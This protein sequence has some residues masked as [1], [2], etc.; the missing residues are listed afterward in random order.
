MP[1]EIPDIN[2][3]TSISGRKGVQPRCPF[4]TVNNCPRFYQSLSLL[5]EAGSTRIDSK[6]DKRLLKRWKKSDL[7]PKTNEYATSIT[8][9]ECAPHTFSNFCPEVAYDRFGY[10]A[11]FL[12]RYADEID[13]N[14]EHAKLGKEGVSAKDWRW[15]WAS[16]SKMHYAECPLYSV[17]ANR[18]PAKESD[19]EKWYKQPIGIIIIGIFITVISGI[20]LHFLI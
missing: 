12:A 13:I 14:V 18:Q 20:I 4:A 19:K 7:W 2:W 9:P 1:T 8:E 11:S 3:Y 5:G 6:E 15:S 17:L 10:F 16:I